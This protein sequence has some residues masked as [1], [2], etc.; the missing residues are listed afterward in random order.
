[1]AE[2]PKSP[3]LRAAPV[4]EASY[5]KWSKPFLASLAATSNV[6]AAAKAARVSTSTVYEAR[7]TNPEFNRKWQ[8]ALCEGYELLEMDLLRRMRE[9]EVKPGA[10]AKRGV[11]TYDNAISMRLIAAHKDTVTR[12]RGI[13]DARDAAEI[14]RSINA[15]FELMR[16]R[17]RAL[18]ERSLPAPPHSDE[19]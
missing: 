15:K 2:T 3:A 16:E 7:R 14:I 10:G 1:M 5:R 9:G 11:R 6:T 12:Q 8:E 18:A 19:Q 4:R 13:R 17:R